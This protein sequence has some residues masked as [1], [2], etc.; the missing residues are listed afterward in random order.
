MFGDFGYGGWEF[1]FYLE[2]TYNDGAMG[3]EV[4]S[5]SENLPQILH[6]QSALLFLLQAKPDTHHNQLEEVRAGITRTVADLFEQKREAEILPALGPLLLSSI[7]PALPEGSLLSDYVN[8]I[9]HLEPEGKV[10][11]MEEL[12]L[13]FDHI[14]VLLGK[15]ASG[16]GTVSEILNK[17]YAVSG[18]A[19]SDWL[20]GIA[21]ARGLPQPFN[22]I[23]LRELADELREEF[24]GDVL[25]WLTI[26]EYNLKGCRNIVFDGLRSGVE[27][28]HLTGQPNVSLIWVEASD[29]KRLERVRSR[30]RPGDP[31]TIEG[32]LEVDRRSFP[33]A[34]SLRDKCQFHFVN[35][36]DDL[37]ALAQDANSVIRKLGISPL[38]AVVTE[39]VIE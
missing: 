1:Y 3:K 17:D 7:L 38:K 19:T 5:A 34:D 25:V 27:L 32:L 8:T 4:T 31:Q 11:T 35:E 20:R 24:G 18:M 21:R 15:K 29:Q 16:K 13:G 30:N 22:P 23:M 33:E 2:C 39:P 10:P 6:D 28:Q 9:L 37:D 12:V 14:V 36:G 26:Q